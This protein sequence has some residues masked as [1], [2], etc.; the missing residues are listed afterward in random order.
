MTILLPILLP[1]VCGACLLAGIVKERRAIQ[2]FAAVSVIVTAVLALWQVIAGDAHFTLLAF[3]D[4]LTLSFRLDGLSRLFG[5]M[6][7]VLWVFTT[8]YAFEYMAHEGGERRFFGFFVMTFGVVLGLAFS[9]NLFSMYFFYEY[10]TFATLPLVMHSMDDRARFAAKRY[11]IYMVTGGALAF[12]ALLFMLQYGYTLDFTLGGALDPSKTSGHEPAL[13][14]AFMVALLGFGVKAAIW[15]MHRWLPSA[16]VAPTPVTALLHAVAVVKSGVFAIAR[17]VYFSF[18]TEILVGSWAQR[19]MMALSILTIVYGSTMALRTPHLKRRLA[20]ST[21]SNL[22][23]IVFG[24]SLMTQAGLE[25]AFL[26]LLFHAVIKIT[27]FFC[28][29]AILVKTG[30]EFGN[31]L[32]GLAKRMPFTCLC[33]TVC[34]LGLIGVPPLAAFHSKWALARAA[35]QLGTP[36]AFAGVCALMLSE[37]LTALY[38]LKPV[39]AMY[40]SKGD[41]A[42]EA[43]DDP[44]PL[45]TV[46]MALLAVCTLVL[47]LISPQLSA[48]IAQLAG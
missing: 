31:D 3:T 45:M 7:S 9:A 38:L 14:V 39:I 25:S 26:H 4:Q 36:L 23:Y 35:V 12:V 1:I 47:A 32:K 17:L 34:A 40:A 22:S 27:L 28:A 8:F 46:P 6:V 41:F 19:G 20:Y 30:L 18:G 24:L 43:H 21:V 29:G 13:R 48:L 44:S 33:F 37:L 5:G 42:I 2:R 10:L 15:P 16:S 11:L